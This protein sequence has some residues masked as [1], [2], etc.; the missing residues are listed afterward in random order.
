[1]LRDMLCLTL[2][3]T[4]T[5]HPPNVRRCEL[6][7]S[8]T[9]PV[10]RCFDW[11][12]ALNLQVS[13]FSGWGFCCCCVL[14]GLDQGNRASNCSHASSFFFSLSLSRPQGHSEVVAIPL[15]SLWWASLSW[16]SQCRSPLVTHFPSSPRGS[17]FVSKGGETPWREGANSDVARV[18]LL[19]ICLRFRRFIWEV[20]LPCSLLILPPTHFFFLCF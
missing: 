1:M 7:G 20:V 11:L 8:V 10:N 14:G 2:V 5:W 16:H 3:L 13:S 9:W 18:E 4:F 17:D 15:V 6:R 12:D 19:T